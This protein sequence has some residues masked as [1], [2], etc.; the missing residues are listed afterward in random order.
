L[1]KLPSVLELSSRALEREYK[2][3]ELVPWRSRNELYDTKTRDQSSLPAAAHDGMQA[4]S[5]IIP[6]HAPECRGDSNRRGG[7]EWEAGSR[8]FDMSA[9]ERARARERERERERERPQQ[10][11]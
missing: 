4:P 3:P 8:E 11:S 7:G 9:T 10:E 2:R 5:I 1:T 6:A